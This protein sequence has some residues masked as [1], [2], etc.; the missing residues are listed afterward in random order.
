MVRVTILGCGDAF[1]SGGRL[2]SA[3]LVETPGSTILV[4]CG[5]TILQALK[6][7]PVDPATIDVV[8]LSH[9]HGDHFGG[10]PF[11]FMEYRYESPRRRPLAVY[12]PPGTA[13]RTQRLFEA[14]YEK[15][16]QEP[17]PFPVAYEELVPGTPRT[18]GD[19]RVLPFAVPH[20]DELCC[21]AYRL[22]AD[23]SAIL[24]SGDSAWTDEFV[25]QARGTDLF[26]CECST[27]EPCVP[28]HISYREIAARAARLECRRLILTHLGAEP[29]RRQGE[30]RL[31]CAQ[32]GMTLELDGARR[33]SRPV[34]PVAPRSDVRCRPTGA[35]R[36]RVRRG[37]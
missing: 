11:L 27:F 14:L 9:L 22:E 26:L 12:G 25:T 8:L 24:Y 23:G 4:D 10:V 3:Y 7:V 1:G 15:S 19:A 13:E 34:R 17:L 30:I 6:R 37:R 16:A 5:P 31:E 35:S 20:V 18:I 33:A 21:L 2:H 29:L 36:G 32:D 28:I